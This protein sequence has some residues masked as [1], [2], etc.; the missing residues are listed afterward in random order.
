M[1]E[2][3]KKKISGCYEIRTTSFKDKRGQFIKTFHKP[4]FESYGLAVDFAEEFYSLS[5][6]NVLRGLHFQLPPHDHDKIIFCLAGKAFDVVLDIRKGSPTFGKYETFE[7]SPENFNMVYI[8]RGL[9]H[10]F[11]AAE[12]N[13]L[14]FYKVTTVHTPDFDSGIHWDSAGINWP[15]RNPIVSARDN[16]FQKFDDFKSPFTFKE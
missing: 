4:T 14:L 12:H 1:F 7:L 15:C 11:Y 10:G 13:T 2:I 9:A 16:S 3:T 5:A 6:K 8:S